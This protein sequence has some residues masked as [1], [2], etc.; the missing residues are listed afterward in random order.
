MSP[1]RRSW[2][3]N[4]ISRRAAMR[5][6]ALALGGVSI[7]PWLGN[8]WLDSPA[9]VAASPARPKAAIMIHLSG[10]PS[11][12][13]MY[14]L[15]PEAPIEYRG[16]FNPIKTNVPG[17]EVCE[18]M[19]KQAQIADK[20]TIL[21]GVQQ[22]HPLHTGNEFYSGYPWQENP[23]AVV[24]GEAQ[25]PSV[26]AIVGR[27]RRTDPQIPPYVSIENHPDW[28]RA[29]YAG[30][31]HEPFRV[32]STTGAQTL[33]NMQRPAEVSVDRLGNRSGLLRALDCTRR[34]LEAAAATKGVNA[35][36]ARALDLITSDRVRNAFDLAQEPAAARK[37][38]GEAEY[39]LGPHPGKSLLLARRLVE[40]GVS[41]VTVGVHN[42]DTHRENFSQLRKMLPPLDQALAALVTDLHDRG[43]LDDVAIIMGGEFG[44]TPRIGDQTPDGRGHWPE[45]GFVWVAGGGFKTGQV[46]GQTDKRGEQP[47]GSP[48][49]MQSI[50]ATLYRQLGIDTT[51]KLPDHNGRPQYVLENR[52]LVEGLI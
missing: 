41:V 32:G 24:P 28:E 46:L 39:H 8:S 18:L 12:L 10:G 50:L 49:R 35:F 36:Q 48:I 26:G 17:I 37:R 23:R 14:D 25:R 42:W 9:A 21:R 30:I 15:K 31:E 20:F 6:G 22:I 38:F 47:T 43:L 52:E 44:R 4:P 19:P 16:E 13:D 2:T 5:S 34:E 51:V 3:N 27:L 1:P 7:S 11:H 29:Y 45:A 33:N 40:A